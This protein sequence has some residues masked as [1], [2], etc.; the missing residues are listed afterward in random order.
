MKRRIMKCMIAVAAMRFSTLSVHA[1]DTLFTD[2]G[3]QA[4]INRIVDA[5]VDNYLA[6]QRIKALFNE[7]NI[8]RLRVEFKV[9]FCQI[10]GGPARV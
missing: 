3:G 6:D 4:G 2:M 1:D 5:S 7:S 10:A 8:E 9:Q